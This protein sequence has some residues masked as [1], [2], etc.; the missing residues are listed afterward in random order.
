MAQDDSKSPVSAFTLFTRSK[1]AVLKN[2]EVYGLVYLLPFLVSLYTFVHNSTHNATRATYP[3]GRDFSGSTTGFVALFGLIVLGLYVFVALLQYVLNS[4]TAEG[5]TPT[6][7]QLMPV[8]QKYGMRLIGLS[9]LIGIY[10]LLGFIAFIVPGL[11]FIRRYY[12]APYVMLDKDLSIREA[13]KESD[14][15]TKPYSGAV[16]GLIGV[17]ILL[18]LTSILPLFGWILS[19]VLTVSYSVAPALRYQEL[20]KLN[21]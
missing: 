11:I 14:R 1:E 19:F 6:F 20:K 8:V 12:L 2:W 18:S 17:S 9:L 16:W 21:K 15:L 4:K 3:W 10:V 5:E 7:G 13:M